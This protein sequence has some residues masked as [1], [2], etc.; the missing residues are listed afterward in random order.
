MQQ[1]NHKYPVGIQRFDTIRAEGYRYVDKTDLVWRLAN[2]NSKSVFLSRPRRFGKT[3]LVSTLEAYFQGRKELFEG[4]AIEGLERSWESF[5][6][7][8]I[9]LSSIKARSVQEL[10]E[11]LDAVLRDQEALL[12]QEATYRLPGSPT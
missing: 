12:G 5:S 10:E 3:L 6:V 4:L 2:G 8:H 9:D 7:I 11:Q 1:I